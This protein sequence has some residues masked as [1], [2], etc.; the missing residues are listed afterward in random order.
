MGDTASSALIKSS[1]ETKYLHFNLKP[2]TLLNQQQV[3]IKS[4]IIQ[5]S[6]MNN[7]RR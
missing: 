6:F 2:E 5:N 7:R 4:D 3:V 1:Q